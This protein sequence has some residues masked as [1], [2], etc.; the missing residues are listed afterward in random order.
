MNIPDEQKNM[1]SSVLG[2]EFNTWQLGPVGLHCVTHVLLT[3]LMTECLSAKRR[4]LRTPTI[5]VCL[6]SPSIH[7]FSLHIFGNFLII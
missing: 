5:I 7:Q 2:E 6:L 3:F 4:V 1:Y